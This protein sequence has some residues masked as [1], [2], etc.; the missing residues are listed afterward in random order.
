MAKRDSQ[1]SK[2]YAAERLAWGDDPY[3]GDPGHGQTVPLQ[4]VQDWVD[5]IT[6]SRFWKT[7]KV[8]I[9]EGHG[10]HGYW[11]QIKRY[12]KILVRDGRGRRNA[13]G[14]QEGYIKLPLWART[15]WVTLH[16]IAH[17]IQTE[18]PAHGRQFARIYLDLVRRFIGPEAARELKRAYVQ[19][20]V[21]S[22][23]KRKSTSKGNP[24]ALKRYR[25][26][27]PVEKCLIRCRA[28]NLKRAKVFFDGE[29]V[30]GE[31]ESIKW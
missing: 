6:R 27:D 23:K 30:P 7:Y 28:A 31:I 29:P 25:E 14:S 9:F 22:T 20:H 17:V 5:M 12:P 4:A 16:E 11:P 21:K 1:R 26:A 15:Y 24:E 18:R 8:P 13:C 3:I 19:K 2:L 10:L